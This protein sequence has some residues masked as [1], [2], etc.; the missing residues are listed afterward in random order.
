MYIGERGEPV[1]PT[2][3]QAQELSRAANNEFGFNT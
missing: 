2:D 1:H 3:P